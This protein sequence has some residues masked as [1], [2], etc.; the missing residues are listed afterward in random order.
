MQRNHAELI[1]AIIFYAQIKDVPEEAQK[2]LLGAALDYLAVLKI[3]PERLITDWP[4]EGLIGG[5]HAF[6]DETIEEAANQ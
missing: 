2:E 4:K 5:F 6:A 1:K 3:V